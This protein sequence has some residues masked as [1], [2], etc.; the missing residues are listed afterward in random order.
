MIEPDRW[1][2]NRALKASG[3]SLIFGSSFEKKIASELQASL[4]RIS[5][6]VI[7]EI[8]LSDMPFIGFSGIA[9]LCEKIINSILTRN[10]NEVKT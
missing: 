3:V 8:S 4:V 10:R 2:M 7:D 5:Y 9:H 6:P 1:D